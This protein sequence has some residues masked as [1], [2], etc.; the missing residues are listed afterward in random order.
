MITCAICDAPPLS[1]GLCLTHAR[2]IAVWGVNPDEAVIYR[3]W[4]WGGQISDWSG[5]VHVGMMLHSTRPTHDDRRGWQAQLEDLCY[6]LRVRP[7]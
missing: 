3:A 5:L 7:Q 6:F 2:L 4:I 1:G